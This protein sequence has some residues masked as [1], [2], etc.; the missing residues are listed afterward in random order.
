MRR[1]LGLV[2]VLL[3]LAPLSLAHAAGLVVIVHP[4]FPVQDITISELSK[5]FLG[6]VSRLAGVPVNPVNKESGSG[7]RNLFDMK[8]HRMDESAMKDYWLAARIK[9]EGN[10]PRALQSDAA[11]M[12]YVTSVPGAIGYVAFPPPSGGARPLSLGGVAPS[13]QSVT[14]GRYPLGSAP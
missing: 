13:P 4:E 11:I 2:L 5:L 8:V 10:P 12:R 14:G 1:T 9:G 7:E 3:A 6:R